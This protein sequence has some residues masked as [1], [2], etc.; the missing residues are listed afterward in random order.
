M[1]AKTKVSHGTRWRRIPKIGSGKPNHETC[2]TCS[3]KPCLYDACDTAAGCAAASVRQWALAR[4]YVYRPTGRNH[5]EI[6]YRSLIF[7]LYKTFQG[8]GAGVRTEH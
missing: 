1:C 8:R 6:I 2:D 7:V 4:F 3:N 5:R